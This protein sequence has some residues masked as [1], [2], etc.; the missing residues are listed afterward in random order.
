VVE[1]ETVVATMMIDTLGEMGCLVCGWATT[2]DDAERLADAV[3]PD[4]VLMDVR[5]KGARCGVEAAVQLR[6]RYGTVIVFVT[7]GADA[8]TVGRMA[9]AK[10]AAVVRKP[11]T[12]KDLRMALLKASEAE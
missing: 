10:P 9:E 6:E 4:V 7:G 8:S 1:D 2:A 12:D 5:L 11:F 3:A